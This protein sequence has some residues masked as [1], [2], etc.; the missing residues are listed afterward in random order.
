MITL[1]GLVESIRVRLDD[2]GG[3]AGTIPAG[4]YAY[5]QYD[6]T[7]CLWKNKELVGY[8]KAV[9]LDV[10]GR[11]PWTAEG[12]IGDHLGVPTRLAVK[13]LNP[14]VIM[15]TATIAVEQIR[16]VSSGLLLTKTTSSQLE[17]IGGFEW[18]T[19]AGVPTHYVEPR[20]GLIRLY[21]IPEDADELRLVVRRRTL[22]EFEWTDVATEE[23][24]YA[25]LPDIPDDLREALVVGVCRLSYLKNDAD[26]LNVP[27]AQEYER[28]F[29]ALVGPVVSWRQK[30]ARREN[31]NLNVA[32]H[33]FGYTRKK[34][35]V[36][37]TE[38]DW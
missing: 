15:N 19:L 1:L 38:E 36:A 28:Q 16:L 25:E 13:A 27:L 35:R 12:T 18:S 22:D 5:W 23:T 14:E 11:A 3:D 21:P 37:D 30:E 34:M 24:P 32:I 8:L 10:A 9:L 31:A 26:T 2:Q 7:S 20:R 33:G 6:D 17:K 29:T 4:Y